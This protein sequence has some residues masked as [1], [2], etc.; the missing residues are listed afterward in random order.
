M[1]GLRLPHDRTSMFH[2]KCPM[3]RRFL[4]LCTTSIGTDND[5]VLYV[6][7]LADPSQCA[8]LRIKIVHGYVEEALDLTGVEVHSD[9][10]VAASSLEHVRHQ[11]GGDG[12]TRLVLLVLACIRKVRQNG[13]DSTCR[14]SLTCVDHDQKLHK[15]IVDVAWRGGLQDENCG[16]MS[17]RRSSRSARFCVPSSS[18]TD[19]PMVT[20][21]S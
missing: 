10:M 12:R 15:S 20:D 14:R 4:P 1:H 5:T 21:V 13:S 11:F 7:V 6:Q 3:G 19:S 16:T 17:S 9:H 18:L 8:G 2:T